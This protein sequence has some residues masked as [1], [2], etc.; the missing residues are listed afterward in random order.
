[1]RGKGL[2]IGLKTALAIFTLAIFTLT[3]FV[4]EASAGTI[5]VLYNFDGRPSYFQPAGVIFDASGN[6][7]GVTPYMVFELAR[8]VDGHW[9]PMKLAQFGSN[10]YAPNTIAFDAAGN[11]YSTASG[12]CCNFAGEVFEL[13]PSTGGGWNEN[14][15]YTLSGGSQGV[16]PAGSVTFDASG[17]IFGT[18]SYTVFELTPDGSGGWTETTLHSFAQGEGSH[19][20]NLIFDANGNLYGTA[21]YGGRYSWGTVWELTPQTDG[22]WE[23]TTLY[24]FTGGDDG[25][26]PGATLK[27]DAAGNLYGTTQGGGH[28]GMGTVFELSPTANGSWREKVLHS[29][30]GSTGSGPT[31]GVIFDTAGNLYGETLSGGADNDGVVFK[32]SPTG[33]GYWSGTVL[34]SFH[35]TD[36]SSPWQGLVF[37]AAGNLYGTAK[38]GGTYGDGSVFEITP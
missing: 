20:S 36:G 10:G 25:A 18:A 30:N 33:T 4:T 26:N 17:N 32:L 29:F 21:L 24:M 3:L 5:K 37:D 8:A 19:L 9:N 6:L 13:S 34:H 31:A 27:F 11:L 14:I 35:G 12:V 38:A 23:E 16:A 15:L 22:T 28:F 2:F 1:M 7:Y